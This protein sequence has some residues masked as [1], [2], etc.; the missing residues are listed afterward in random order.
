MRRASIPVWDYALVT[1]PLSDGHRESLGWRHRQGAC[2]RGN[3]FHYYRLTADHRILWGGYDAIYHFGSRIDPEFQQRPASFEGLS[4]R[5]F[6]TFPQLAGLR[7]THSWGGPIASTTRFCMDVGTACG[8]RVSWAIGYTG[9][10]VVASRFGARVA[11]DL[12]DRPDAPHLAL[13]LVRKRSFPWPP[14]PLRFL[15]VALTQRALARAD[16]NQ[17]HRGPWLRLLDLAGLGFD[18]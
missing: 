10:G 15:G 1:E 9:L 3:R 8:R 2:D 14:E 4:R 13:R 11:L 6:E 5:F 17:G 7:F 12:L 16:R 18:S